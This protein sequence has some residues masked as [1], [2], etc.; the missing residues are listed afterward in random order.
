MRRDAIRDYFLSKCKPGASPKDFWNAIGPFMSTKTKSQRNIILKEEDS[1]I[2]DTSD[3]CEIFIN[4]FSTA[5]NSIGCPDEIDMSK[6]RFFTNIIEKHKN[7]KSI[8]SIKEHFKSMNM[9]FDFN[10]VTP[11]YVK[12]ILNKI[13]PNKSTGYDDIPPK[14]VK[15]CSEELSCTWAELINNAF[16]CKIF[17]DD[18]KKAEISPIYKKKD[19]MMKDNYRPVSILSVFSKVYETIIAD[20]LMGYFKDIFDNMLCAYRKKYGTQHVLVKL[21]DSWKCALDENKYAG[22][23]LMDLCKAFDCV[24]H[25]LLIAKMHAYGLSKNACEF[26]ASYLSDRCQRVRISNEK[27]TWMPL[28]KGVPQGSCL[29]PLLFNIFMNDIFYFM[30]SCDLIN[31]ADDNTLSAVSNTIDSV[32]CSLRQDTESAINWF[33]ENFMQVNPAK[34]QFMFIKP[35]MCRYN[36]PDFIE[37]HDT[38]IMCENEVKLLGVTIDNK[39]KFD[40]H[41]DILCKKAAKQLNVMY[42]FKGIFDS[43]EKEVIYNTFILSNFNYCPIVWHFCGKG[44]TKKIEAIQE[45]ALRFMFNDKKSTYDSLLEKCNYTTLHIRRIKTIATEVFKSLHDM[46]PAFMKDIFQQKDIS[47]GLRDEV[48]LNQPKFHKLSYGRNTFKYYGSHIWNLLPNEAKLS[49]NIE[50]FKHLIKIWDGPKCQCTMCDAL[51]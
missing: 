13:N 24:P 47:Y 26:M 18:L 38:K 39:L 12:S 21:I 4:F 41:V 29:G 16:K 31:Y 15:M 33:V 14:V 2:T 44:S 32:I 23:L 7:H 45:R 34:F 19:D 51:S 27:S 11:A 37:I 6:D 8:F 17:P 1:V 42:R 9:T 40:R 46:N 10:P 35:V 3:L 20:Q 43:K 22:T 48:I 5:A 25:G 30:E 49:T 50:S 28:L 36:T